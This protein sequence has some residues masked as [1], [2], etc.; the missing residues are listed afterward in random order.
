MSNSK[1]DYQLG[2]ERAIEEL[3]WMARGYVAYL[4]AYIQVAA[5][6]AHQAIDHG[7]AGNYRDGIEDV[8]KHI[9]D[10]LE[11]E[12]SEIYSITIC[13]ME[14]RLLEIEPDPADDHFCKRRDGQLPTCS[15]EYKEVVQ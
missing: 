2:V 14:S 7:K 12:D 4:Y 1:T 5:D 13:Q 11:A 3:R 10:L 15:R 8:R 6:G 9:S